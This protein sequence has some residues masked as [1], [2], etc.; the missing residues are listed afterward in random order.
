MATNMSNISYF[1]HYIRACLG[2]KIAVFLNKDAKNH[3]K[4]VR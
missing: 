4:R 1:V 3:I 2:H